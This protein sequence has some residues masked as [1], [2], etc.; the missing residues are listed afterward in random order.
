MTG[1]LSYNAHCQS[2]ELVDDINPVSDSNP[3]NFLVYNNKLYFDAYIAAYGT[4]LWSTDGTA[5]GT[6]LVKDINPGSGSSF[7][8]LPL[9]YRSNIYFTATDS[10][11]S[12][13]WQSDGTAT[14]TTLMKYINSNFGQR[15]YTIIFNGKIYF[16]ASDS[17][18]G[19]EL[20]V[21]DGTTSGT[22]ILAD[23]YP[24]KGSSHPYGFTACNS[25]I[26]F[27]ANDSIHGAELWST[28]GTTSGT[29]LVKD[30]N[31]GVIGSNAAGFTVYNNKIYFSAQDTSGTHIWQTDGNE[32]RTIILT[33]STGIL[34][35]GTNFTV[36]DS[37]LFFAGTDT[38]HG[39]ELWTT[40]GTVAGTHLVSDIYGGIGSGN[41]SLMTAFRGV[42]FFAAQNSASGVELWQSDG[43]SAGTTV[44]KAFDIGIGGNISGSFPIYHGKL[45]MDGESNADGNE[46]W[47]TDG[48]PGGT[49][50]IILA[51]ALYPDALSFNS[52]EYIVYNDALYFSAF[53][54]NA[55]NELYRVTDTSTLTDIDD[56][57]P[58]HMICYPNPATTKL[59]ISCV[60][61]ISHIEIMDINGSV[62]MKESDTNSI[63][64][65]S[66]AASI[67]LARII[68]AE[69]EAKILKFLKE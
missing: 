42:L 26:Y 38:V 20:W 2:V 47:N 62:I 17:T 13:I 45:Y 58:T 44:V 3:G 57:A 40:D 8:G 67:Y 30:I 68:N 39:S 5:S 36:I 41:P 1:V 50:E 43:T 15:G 37:L 31:P 12:G 16:Q 48:T 51:G 53:Y 9:I 46:L 18:H 35:G 14:G 27:R 63:S 69:G 25:K 33:D 59:N 22:T 54:N 19:G 56:I 55:G 65:E 60:Y 29:T 21:S 28:D 10:I 66:L 64:I 32:I 4:E 11:A 52:G 34:Q 6:A 24:G 7:P 49:H 61:P 23:I